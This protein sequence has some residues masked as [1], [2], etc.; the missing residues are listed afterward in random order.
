MKKILLFSFFTALSTGL[1]A[2]LTLTGT[3]YTQN[4]DGISSG[5]PTGW[6]IADSARAN[7]LG[8][9]IPTSFFSAPTFGT[10]GNGTFF[11]T[12]GGFKNYPSAD[13]ASIMGSDSATQV[14]ATNRAL[15]VRQVTPNS[16]LF[17]N[18]DPGAAFILQ[19][20]NTTGFRTFTATFKLQSLDTSSPRV[21][22]W[23]VD[24]SIGATPTT[25]TPATVTGTMTTG[26][27]SFTNNTI[28]V[29][30]GTA[31][32]NKS[33][34]VWIRI[35]TL[36]S[37]TGSGN[38]TSTT[39]DDFNLSWLPLS[40]ATNNI[41]ENGANELKVL[42]KATSTNVAMRFVTDI[43]GDY[44]LVI[45]DIN[46]SVR[47]NKEY[48]VNTETFPISITNLQLAPG[49]YVASMANNGTVSKVKFI[50]E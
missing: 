38:R 43:P 47:Y 32:N 27:H 28:N 48:K 34:P 8:Q 26:G 20:N 44:K 16:N 33:Q 36:D 14:T 49:M 50:V 11:S 31:L 1:H 22:T 46:G 9:L 21:T 10:F 18:S 15:G 45:S 5:L 3:S 29:D 12:R 23:I 41:Q 30:F 40:T 17:P 37:S 25:F 39:I 2:Q 4:F 35:V 13:V 42:G 6:T 24:Y 19:L 7:F